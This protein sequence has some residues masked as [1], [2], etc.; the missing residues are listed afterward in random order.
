MPIIHNDFGPISTPE[1]ISLSKGAKANS[2]TKTASTS[3]WT[4]LAFLAIKITPILNN[5]GNTKPIAVSSF[6][7]PVF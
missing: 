6:T 1:T 4:S 2:P 7:K 5:A 3:K